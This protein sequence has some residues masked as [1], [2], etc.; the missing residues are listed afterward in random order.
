MKTSTAVHTVLAVG[1]LWVL[2]ISTGW[3]QKKNPVFAPITDDA[4]LPRVLLIGDSISI[5]YTLPVRE[6]LK[7]KANVHRV[8]TNAGN[9]GMGLEGLPKWLNEKNGKWDV[10]H[11]NWG[12]WDLCYRNPE[13]KNQGHRDKENGT[14]THS[15]EEYVANLE[16]IVQQLEQSGATLIFATTTP[17]PEGELGRKTGDDHR[18]NQAALEVMKKHHIAIDDLHAVMAGKMEKYGKNPG[19]VHYTPEGYERLAQQVARSIE[20]A[21][22]K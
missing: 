6:L 9:T 17:V 4:K 19:D 20:S 1:V 15:V 2:G 11:F 21:L 7:G 12:L 8:P 22:A 5:G 3:S 18:Y 13:S 14:I 16:T 10:I